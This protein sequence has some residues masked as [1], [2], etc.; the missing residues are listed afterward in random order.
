MI[1]LEKEFEYYLQHQ[2]DIVK[3][4]EGK[5]VV[6]K[7]KEVIGAYNSEI[8]ALRETSKSFALG[9]FL[10][11]KCEPGPESYTQTYHSRVAFI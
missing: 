11:Q 8:E 2:G 1:P 7:D 4:Y 3:K 6:I 10:I 9:T 5:F